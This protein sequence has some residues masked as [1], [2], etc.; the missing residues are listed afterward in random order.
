MSFISWLQSLSAVI[1]EP[2]KI[3]SVMVS[4]VSPSICHEVMGPDAMIL[5]FWPLSFKS[6]FCFP[7]GSEGKA[8]ACNAGDLGSISDSGRSPG[9]GNGNPLQYPYL[10]NP[11]DWG[12]LVGYSPWGCKESDTTG[13]LHS[14][15]H[16][17]WLSSFTLIK[18]LFASSLLSAI[19]MV[20]SAYLRLLIFLPTILIP[21]CIIATSSC[22]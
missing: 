4:I 9:A 5:V 19:R 12:S 1:L 20:S 21:A 7:G 11:M 13:W 8:S 17:L 2:K 22:I 3:K 14:L 16:S 18:R 6:T 10:E 15:I